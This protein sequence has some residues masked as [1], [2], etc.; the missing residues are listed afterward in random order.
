M[1]AHSAAIRNLSEIAKRGGFLP[2]LPTLTAL[3]SLAPVASGVIRT[4]NSLR[5][6]QKTGQG[7]YLANYK[8][9]GVGMKWNENRKH[10]IK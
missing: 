4:V 1:S 9:T 8:K 2:L 5:N 3:R 10:R 6:I 7:F